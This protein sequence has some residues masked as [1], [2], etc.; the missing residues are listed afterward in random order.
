MHFL[1]VWQKPDVFCSFIIHHSF[2]SVKIII[3]YNIL[4]NYLFVSEI[5]EI[6]LCVVEMQHLS[7]HS[8][9]PNNWEFE[10][11]LLLIHKRI[12]VNH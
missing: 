10:V 7:C 4:S 12:S 2:Y 8:V 6:C 1:S 9:I 11:F 3:L 5:A